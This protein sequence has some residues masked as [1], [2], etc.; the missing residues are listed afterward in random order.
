MLPLKAVN[1]IAVDEAEV[2]E[3]SGFAV[4]LARV[5]CPEAI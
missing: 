1:K 2:R 5:V 4:Y 3:R